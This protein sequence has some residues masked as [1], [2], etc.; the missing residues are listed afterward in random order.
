M[1]FKSLWV[2]KYRP[3]TLDDII[4]SDENRKILQSYSENKMI[5]HLFFVSTPGK[6]KTSLAKIIVNDILKCDYLYINAS[7]ENGIDT[8]RYKITGFAQTKSFD[9]NIKTIILDECLH[10]DTLVTV[11]R[12][13]TQQ[14]IKIK[15]VDDRNDF[16]KSYNFYKK[17]IEW[18][19][20]YKI[21]KG[22]QDV[23]E[24][25]F[26][27]GEII[28]CTNDHKWHVNDPDSNIPIRKKLKEI[29][30]EGINEIITVDYFLNLNALK[31]E[32][33]V[34]HENTA[35]VYDLSVDE[36]H[37]FFVGEKQVLTSNCDS[38]SPEAMRSLRNT[39]EEYS[40]NTRFILTAN[41]KHK[42][43]PAIQSRCQT[44]EFEYS[45]TDVAKHLLGI[46]NKENILVSNEQILKLKTLIK[47]DFPDI[48]KIINTVQKYSL[49]GTLDIK[50]NTLSDTFVEEIFLKLKKD[51]VFE[52]REYVIKNESAF[53]SDY[54]NL[55]KGLLNLI[56]EKNIDP[57]KK[58]ECILIIAEHMYRHTFVMDI[59]IN[60][61]SCFIGLSKLLF[62]T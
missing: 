55:L 21:D 57:L 49:S 32:K 9:G 23:Y 16:V 41:Y 5:P 1:D 12:N 43:I 48:R 46:L 52:V 27:N 60:A 40:E 3:K 2:E 59:E 11:V 47:T 58:K 44:L 62:G 24:I 54:H 51:E 7:D 38:M 13:K 14:Q 50:E 42:V 26:E 36:T 17:R 34:K 35:R 45:I 8:I 22:T 31:I 37:N 29:I 53:Q 19:P 33:I 10:E 20:F 25:H 4:L 39:I 56:Y 6:G 61:F 28:S 15:N 18:K 30:E